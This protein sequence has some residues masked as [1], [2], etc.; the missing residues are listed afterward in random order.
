[1]KQVTSIMYAEHL[2][3][4]HKEGFKPLTYSQYVNLVVKMANEGNK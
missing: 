1:M 4:G 3:R 2:A